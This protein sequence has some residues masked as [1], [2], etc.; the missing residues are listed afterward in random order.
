MN[1]A[2]VD[3]MGIRIA[4]PNLVYSANDASSWFGSGVLDKPFSDFIIGSSNTGNTQDPRLYFAG[5][6]RWHTS[7]RIIPEPEEYALV[8]G[9]FAL[10]FVILHRCFQKEGLN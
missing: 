9:L 8:V 2:N 10:A 1:D 4:P 3:E 5:G 7:G 6:V